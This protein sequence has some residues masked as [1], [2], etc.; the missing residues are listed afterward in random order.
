MSTIVP[1][2]T[3][4]IAARIRAER[5]ARGWSLTDAAEKSGVSRAMISKVERGESSPTAVLLGRLCGAFGLTMSTLLARAEG[6][7][8]RVSRAGQQQI[9]TDSETRYVRRSLSPRPGGP[10]DL[11]LIDLPPGANVSY[12]AASYSFTRHQIWVQE[13]HLT[14]VEGAETHELGPGDCLELGP[15]SD[16]TFSNRSD[17]PCRYLVAVAIR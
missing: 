11:V 12:P 17:R 4:R 13:G 2:P 14:F 8:G 10:L 15:A 7:T 16:C 5:E 9:W 1:D 6:E 3:A